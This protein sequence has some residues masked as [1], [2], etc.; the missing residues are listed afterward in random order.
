[1]PEKTPNPR[2]RTSELRQALEE[3]TGMT[4]AELAK[5]IGFL[6]LN[7]KGKLAVRIVLELIK[8]L[9]QRKASVQTVNP[10][11]KGLVEPE[12][13]FLDDL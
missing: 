12:N 11:R 2:N 5:E 3:H 6:V 1:M 8:R 10:G 4:D 7:N 9:K 13:Y